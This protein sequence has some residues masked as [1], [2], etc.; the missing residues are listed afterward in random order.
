MG[1]A[2]GVDFP[3]LEGSSVTDDTVVVD[4]DETASV[5]CGTTALGGEMGRTASKRGATADLHA[6]ES[7]CSVLGCRDKSVHRSEGAVK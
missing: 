3:D 4:D 7:C 5:S 6:T 1:V 2:G